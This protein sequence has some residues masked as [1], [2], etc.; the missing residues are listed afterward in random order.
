MRGHVHREGLA[1][2]RLVASR[3]RRSGSP[4]LQ[5]ALASDSSLKG[6][7]NLDVRIGPN[8][9]VCSANIPSNDM[10][11]AGVAACAANIFRK[12]SYPAPHGGCVVA[13]VPLSFVPL[14]Q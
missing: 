9:N 14:G 8:G 6:H 11:S 5:Q 7:V 10:G 2:A 13:T 12:P 1:G 3:A 4:L